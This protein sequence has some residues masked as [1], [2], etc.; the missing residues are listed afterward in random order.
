L[1]L[2]LLRLLLHAR[3]CEHAW[4]LLLLLLLLQRQALLP[5]SWL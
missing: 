4:Y 2:R 3:C 1:R 5:T